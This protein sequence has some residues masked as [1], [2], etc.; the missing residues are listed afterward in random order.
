MTDE[1]K[2]KRFTLRIEKELFAKVQASA[3]KNK[4]STG[5]EMEMLLEKALEHTK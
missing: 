2:I 1:E 5:K 3:E 4:R